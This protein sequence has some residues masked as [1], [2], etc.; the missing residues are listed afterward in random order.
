M[1][2]ISSE[3]QAEMLV[4]YQQFRAVG[5]ELNNSL[6]KSL[7]KEAIT[8]AAEQLGMLERGV[9]VFDTEDVSSVLMDYAV[10]QIRRDGLNAVERFLSESPPPESDRMLYARSLAKVR[11]SLIQVESSL[12]GFGIQVRD[13]LRNEPMLVLDVNFSRTAEQGIVLAAHV[14]CP[15]DFCMTTGASL[16]VTAEIL[17]GLLRQLQRR[18]GNKPRDYRRLSGPQQAGLASLTIRTCLAAGMAQRVRYEDLPASTGAP[19]P[20]GMQNARKFQDR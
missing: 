15:E 11:Y 19:P 6:V 12:P 4:R 5:R 3:K 18:F 20:K 8:E 9:I 14:H 7:G 1:E 2:A 10:H 16:P 17:P 13:I